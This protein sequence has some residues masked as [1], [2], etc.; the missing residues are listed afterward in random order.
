[1][2]DNLDTDATARGLAEINGM[3]LRFLRP[4]KDVA[5]VRE[6]QAAEAAQAGGLQALMGMA[7][8]AGK[9]VPALQAM[10]EGGNG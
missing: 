5:A 7:D 2:F 4:E 6:S 1:V 3:P 8:A 10:K 9:A